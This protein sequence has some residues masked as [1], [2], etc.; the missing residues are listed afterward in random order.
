MEIEFQTDIG[1]KRRNNQDY[2][3]IFYNQAAVPFAVLADGMGGHQAGDIASRTTV[4][5]LG[6]EWEANQLTDT[7][8]I[9]DWLTQYIQK[10]N[11]LI[12]EQGE[13]DQSLTGMGTTIVAVVPFPQQFLLAHVGDSRCYLYQNKELRQLTEDHSLVNEL[14]KRGEITPEMAINHPHKNV[15]IRSVGMPGQV[16]VDTAVHQA[17][18]DDYLLL[19]SDGLTNMVT[20]QQIAAI[21]DA[22]ISLTKKVE[23]LIA[24]ANQAGGRDNIT[25]LLVHY[26]QPEEATQ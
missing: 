24:Q 17:Q 1:Q 10:E 22:E 20:D 14:V 15:L 7:E 23:Q 19:C 9:M 16:E 6:A 12:Y 11:I 18:L 26:D 5:D 2:A 25:V 4:E 21:L 8:A 13:Q 3:G